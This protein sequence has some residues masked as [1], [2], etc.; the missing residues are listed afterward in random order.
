MYPRGMRHAW[1][2]YLLALFDSILVI[3]L[4]G[5]FS[6]ASVKRGAAELG[7]S[8]NWPFWIFYIFLLQLMKIH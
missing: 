5:A 7:G 2:T 4:W 1:G 8:P 3:W 6:E